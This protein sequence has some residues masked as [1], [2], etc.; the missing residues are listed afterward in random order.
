[1]QNRLQSVIFNPVLVTI[2]VIIG[3]L[4]LTGLSYDTYARSGHMIEFWLK[5]A[6][7]ALGVP[8]YSQLRAIRRQFMPILVS[9]LAGGVTG[10]VSVVLL[11]RLLGASDDVIISLAPKSVTSPIAIEITSQLGGIPALTGAI[12][13]CVGLIGA[14]AGMKILYLGHISSPIAQ[15][16]SMGTAA[17]VIGT[18]RIT[19]LG[20]R[21]GAYATV[22]LILNGVLTAL[23]AQPLLS[24]LGII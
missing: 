14:I 9:Q 12:V 18:S 8:L 6:I 7:V 13:V 23:L 16:I 19:Q 24:L 15:G 3:F 21:Y 2:V 5:P 20:E 11:A 4:K 10:V 1:L 17:H 22:G